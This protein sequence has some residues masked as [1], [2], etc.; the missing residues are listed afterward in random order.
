MKL[1]CSNTSAI[2]IQAANY[3]LVMLIVVSIP[4][5]TTLDEVGNVAA[6]E[7]ACMYRIIMFAFTTCLPVVFFIHC[8]CSRENCY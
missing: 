4:E 2:R 3:I 8:T 5:H 7:F 1:E 6:G